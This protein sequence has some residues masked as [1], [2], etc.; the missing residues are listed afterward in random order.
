MNTALAREALPAAVPLVIGLLLLGPSCGGSQAGSTSIAFESF[1]TDLNS[2]IYIASDDGADIRRLTKG[3]NPSW[4]PGG[5]KLV[6]ADGY[7]SSFADIYVINKDGSGRRLL[8]RDGDE[9]IWSPDRQKHR[10][11]AIRASRMV[12]TSS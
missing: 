7:D 1:D 3:W 4:S 8:V 11:S 9:P 6:F 12:R 2:A 5:D 10:L